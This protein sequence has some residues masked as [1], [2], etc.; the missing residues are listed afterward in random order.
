MV[1]VADLAGVMGWPEVL[2]L[3]YAWHCMSQAGSPA[4]SGRATA[5][6]SRATDDQDAT[7]CPDKVS[8][9]P[10]L[11]ALHTFNRPGITR[12]VKGLMM[13]GHSQ[14]PRDP[15]K[16]KAAGKEE[17]AGADQLQEDF[18]ALEDLFGDAAD[19]GR[20]AIALDALLSESSGGPLEATAKGKADGSSTP[21]V[22][23]SKTGERF[24]KE[25]VEPSP[26]SQAKSTQTAGGGA[27]WDKNRAK[28][29]GG[30]PVRKPVTLSLEESLEARKSSV[31]RTSQA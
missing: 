28:S 31:K 21:A 10:I 16:L 13:S 4:E 23:V 7:D 17:P 24:A 20:A 15:M 8:E 29:G 12:K 22:D 2:P 6:A 14:A 27:V 3:H 19:T 30:A 18:D 11:G 1:Q 5:T 25:T 9:P 26:C